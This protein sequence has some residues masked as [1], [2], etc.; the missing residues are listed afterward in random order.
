MVSLQ[1]GEHYILSELPELLK[2]GR[3]CIQVA[4]VLMVEPS[5]IF[6]RQLD[7]DE[8]ARGVGLSA[9]PEQKNPAKHRPNTQRN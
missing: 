8:L 3:F 1:T 6:R 9:P 5:S 7:K 4:F 2:Q